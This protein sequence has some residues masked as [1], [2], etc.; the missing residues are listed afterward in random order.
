MEIWV[1]DSPECA[2]KDTAPGEC[3]PIL[4]VGLSHGWPEGPHF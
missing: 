1:L 4:Q 2:H 3:K